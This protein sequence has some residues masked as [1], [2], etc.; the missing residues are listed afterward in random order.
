MI[1]VIIPV[2]NAAAYLAETVQSV[3]A[4]TFSAWEVLI[5]NDGSK[6]N[7]LAIAEEISRQD[8]RISVLSQTNAGVS[9]ARNYGLAE[10]RPDFPF[11]L[12]LDSDDLL[13]PTALQTLAALLEAQPEAPAACGFLQD[14]DAGGQ[15]LGGEVRLE[16]LTQRRGVEGTRLVSRKPDA[17]LV[18]GDICFHNHIITAGQVLI[19]KSALKKAGAFTPAF[20]YVADY[21]LWW[22]LVMQ[23]GPVAVTPERV[24]LYRHHSAS[25][26][27]NRASRNQDVAAFRWL[28]LTHPGMSPEQKRVA[29]TGY[30]YHCLVGLEFGLYYMRR[31]EIKHGLKHAGLGLRDMLYYT[32][33]L[34][35]SRR[36]TAGLNPPISQ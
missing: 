6:D 28:L 3:Q 7:S 24:L 29:R 33:D 18:F 26:S 34:V 1:S 36:R 30:L 16:A 5:V 31:G 22:R 13:V 8:S 27:K 19:R 17:P 9:T 32:R 15:P 10:S 12:F 25:M 14:V 21:D 11:A 35:R 4:Q 23:V 2:Y 20:S